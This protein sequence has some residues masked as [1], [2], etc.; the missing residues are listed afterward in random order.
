MEITL[1]QVD[2][3][4]ER[5]GVSYSIAK[6]AL[7]KNNGDV[8]NSIIYIEENYSVVKE[9]AVNRSESIDDFKKWLKETIEKGNVTRIRI[10]KDQA[11][12]VDIPVN[13]G[14]AAGVIAICIPAILAFGLIAAVATKITIE[15]TMEDGSVKVVNKYIDKVVD[16]VRDKATTVTTMVKGKINETTSETGRKFTSSHKGTEE[17]VFSYTVNFDDMQE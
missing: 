16:E 11:E 3:V 7:E 13:A 15:I 5:T 9:N 6:D 14:I 10:T 17:T 1:E 12:I 2:K 8:L 4:R